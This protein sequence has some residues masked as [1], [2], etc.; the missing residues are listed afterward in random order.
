MS[1]KQYIRVSLAAG[2]VM[3]AAIAFT[4]QV[5]LTGL[6]V[7]SAIGLAVWSVWSNEQ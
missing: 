2:I 5:V 1:D 7:G 3:G 4:G 6:V